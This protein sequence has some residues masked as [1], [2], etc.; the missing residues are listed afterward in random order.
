M[1]ILAIVIAGIVLWFAIKWAKEEILERLKAIM[2]KQDIINRSVV[3]I[4]ALDSVVASGIT[5][6]A[7]IQA[8]YVA[9]IEATKAANPDL[10]TSDLDAATNEAEAA[11][12]S[13][14]NAIAASTP[15]SGEVHTDDG[16]TGTVPVAAGG[17]VIDPETVDTSAVTAPVDP[18]PVDLG[19]AKDGGADV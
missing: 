8:R 1:D 19:G 3:T 6:M 15:A 11:R 13:L 5:A 2:E 14:A 7:V 18:D 12:V 4:R 9:A 16:G 10:D 17:T